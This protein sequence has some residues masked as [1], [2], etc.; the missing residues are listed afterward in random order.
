MKIT[1]AKMQ[2]AG[3]YDVYQGHVRVGTV[4]RKGTGGKPWWKPHGWRVRCETREAAA[5]F[6]VACE[7]FCGGAK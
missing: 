1:F 6:L 4:E 2:K 5:G 3:L 7:T